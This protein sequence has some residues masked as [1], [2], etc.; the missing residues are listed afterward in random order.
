MTGFMAIFNINLTKQI[1]NFISWKIS[2]RTLELG[3]IVFVGIQDISRN[4]F[5]IDV[6]S[7]GRSHNPPEVLS[8]QWLHQLHVPLSVSNIDGLQGSPRKYKT[9]NF[10]QKRTSINLLPVVD[11]IHFSNHLWGHSEEITSIDTKSVVFCLK[12]SKYLQVY[13]NVIIML[14]T[15]YFHPRISGRLSLSYSRLFSLKNC[16]TT[17]GTP[18][19]PVTVWPKYHQDQWQLHL[20]LDWQQLYLHCKDTPGLQ[21]FHTRGGKTDNFWILQS[22]H[23]DTKL[24]MLDTQTSFYNFVEIS[25][26][27]FSNLWNMLSW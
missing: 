1:E 23:Q 8:N 18:S 24:L 5:I 9:I 27:T 16:S 17:K 26:N 22:T 7:S 3:V 11:C 4:I 19:T 10:D 2:R 13:F 14:V 12:T 20:C 6:S 15:L 21:P 25:N